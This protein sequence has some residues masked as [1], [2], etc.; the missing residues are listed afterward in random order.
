[1]RIDSGI[2]SHKSPYYFSEYWYE[3]KIVFS[4]F[5]T[6]SSSFKLI[7]LA[8]V[9]VVYSQRSLFLHDCTYWTILTASVI[10][11]LTRLVLQEGAIVFFVLDLQFLLQTDETSISPCGLQSKASVLTWLYWTVHASVTSMFRLTRRVLWTKLC[12]SLKRQNKFIFCS[13]ALSPGAVFSKSICGHKVLLG[14]RGVHSFYEFAKK[15]VLRDKRRVISV[16]YF[17]VRIMVN[18]PQ[19]NKKG[20]VNENAH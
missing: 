3:G 17:K 6:S 4:L 5:S 13:T 19:K 20:E 7:R 9:H 16:C 14:V 12:S 18:V 11:C 15:N 8:S 2:L 1:M 10:F